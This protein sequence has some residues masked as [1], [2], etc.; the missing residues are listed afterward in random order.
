MRVRT[1]EFLQGSTV[2]RVKMWYKERGCD[3]NRAVWMQV[4]KVIPDF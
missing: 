1:V 3:L 4:T 2:A